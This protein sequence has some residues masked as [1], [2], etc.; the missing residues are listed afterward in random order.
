MDFRRWLVL[1]LIGLMAA[2]CT[3]PTSPATIAPRRTAASLGPTDLPTPT[4]NRLPAGT[5]LPA[6]TLAPIP[7]VSPG[8]HV[9]GPLA[10]A[11][12][13][14]VY[15][16]FDCLRCAQLAGMLDELLSRHPQ[17][18][19]MAFRLFPHI[20]TSPKS[21][22][23]GQVA[24]LAAEQDAFWPMHDRLFAGY[25]EWSMLSTQEFLTWALSQADEL[26]LDSAALQTG[27]NSASHAAQ[28]DE[29]Y[30]RG[31]AMG[32]PGSPFLLL[33]GEPYLLPYSPNYLE[34]AVRLSALRER[35]F[36]QYPELTL[37]QD[38]TYLARLELDVGELLLQLYPQY[39]PLAVNSFVFLAG[40]GWFDGTA[41]YQVKPGVFVE[42]GDPTGTGLGDPGYYF[43][44]EP[45]PALR[46]DR[47]GVV[48]L[49][50]T[51]PETNGARFF[52][53]LSPLPELDGARTIFGRVLQG[54]ELLQSLP[55]RDP[56][57]DLLAPPPAVLLRVLIEVQ[58]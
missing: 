54:M 9:R 33:D 12:T 17:D 31:L 8:E 37:D 20:E 48:A 10:A 51:S 58:R 16:E 11:S 41:V 23:A 30:R 3:Q 55:E 26:G 57:G 46:F 2:A 15:S 50:P 25:A 4:A 5:P 21:S 1:A 19:R 49:V 44:M 34:A 28:M 39:A 53:S 24:E 36:G 22:L 45:S 32:I 38:A 35:Q 6:A 27:L 52:I 42:A 7:T 43:G 14:I 29:A 56:L 13:L 40:Q 47:P 18:L